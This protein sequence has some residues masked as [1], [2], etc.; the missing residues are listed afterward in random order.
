[1]ISLIVPYYNSEKWLCRCLES[2]SSQNSTDIEFILVDDNS[3]DKSREIVEK[4]VREEPRG[5]SIENEGIPG[6][7]GAR[8][9]GIEN[10]KGEWITFLDSDDELNLEL[11]DKFKRE[12]VYTDNGYNIYQ[13]NHLRSYDEINNVA[14]KYCNNGGEYR[15]TTRLK[16][17]PQQWWAVWNKFY[18]ASLLNENNIRFN[19]QMRYGEDELFNLECLA[20]DGR[21]W[22]GERNI[23]TLTRHFNNKQSL[24]H[25]RD[26]A[27]VTMQVMET[28]S[29]QQRTD[30]AT[31]KLFICDL[32]ADHWSNGTYRSVLGGEVTVKKSKKNR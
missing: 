7:G 16:D 22:H 13:F 30:N 10:A 11:V 9:T 32:L 4:W 21:I 24:S 14:F 29:L 28:M 1:M 17:M 20:C 25:I 15:L 31:L 8:N 12:Y 18:R 19:A 26:V 5:V 27:E 2:L 23:V 6:V 3:T